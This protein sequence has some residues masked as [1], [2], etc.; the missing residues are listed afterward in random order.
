MF[1]HIVGN[2]RLIL[3][4]GNDLNKDSDVLTCR[5]PGIYLFSVS[6]TTIPSNTEYVH[7]NLLVYQNNEAIFDIHIYSNQ[8]TSNKD[9]LSKSVNLERLLNANDQVYLSDYMFRKI[10]P[11]PSM[12]FGV[13]IRADTFFTT[14]TNNPMCQKYTFKAI[15]IISSCS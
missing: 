8:D 13:L 4:E 15:N 1:Y 14:L 12:F 2:T 3:N 9:H 6:L 5:T 10:H 7:C 11:Y